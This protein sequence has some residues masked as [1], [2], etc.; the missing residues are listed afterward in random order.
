MGSTD[1]T[2][3]VKAARQT[4]AVKMRTVCAALVMAASACAENMVQQQQ[5]YYPA[6]RSDIVDAGDWVSVPTNYNPAQP[7]TARN[8]FELGIHQ[9]AGVDT[10]PIIKW[11]VGA[12]LIMLI[13]STVLS[14]GKKVWPRMSEL[15]VTEKG[16]SLEQVSSLA[17]YAFEAFEKYQA[18]NEN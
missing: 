17:Q 16:R 18:L 11:G 14:L 13:V 9:G 15:M 1:H 10:L 4:I 6:Q 2:I 8:P 3:K 5:Q 7:H 12:V